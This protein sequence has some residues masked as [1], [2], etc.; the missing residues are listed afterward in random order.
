MKEFEPDLH[1]TLRNILNSEDAS[2]M[3]LTFSTSYDNFGREETVEFR[4]GG[5]H[6]AVTNENK[7]EFVDL[8]LD[9]YFNKSVSKQFRPFYNGFFKVMSQESIRVA[10]PNNSVT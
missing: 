5:S 8:Y 9:W 10:F 4:E 1:S 3:D 7:R 6:M 2:K